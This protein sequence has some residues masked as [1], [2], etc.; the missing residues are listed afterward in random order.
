MAELTTAPETSS[1]CSPAAQETCCEPSGKS[2]CC[3]T[4]AAGGSCG[5]SAGQ[6]A[7]PAKDIRETVRE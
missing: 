2:A 6:T 4:S 3:G 1:C 7:D 5:C